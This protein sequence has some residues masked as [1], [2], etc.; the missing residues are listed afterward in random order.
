MSALSKVNNPIFDALKHEIT[1]LIW[2]CFDEIKD[3]SIPIHISIFH[4]PINISI[5]IS[6]LES[7]IEKL[8]GDRPTP[9]FE[10][11]SPATDSI[12]V[13]KARD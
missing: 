5:K 9:D 11:I 10:I 8:V 4:V 6:N 12:N 7:I 3:D 1:R 2:Q 13:N